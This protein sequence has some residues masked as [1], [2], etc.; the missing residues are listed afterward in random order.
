MFIETEKLIIRSI[1]PEDEQAY[2]DMASGGDLQDI[3]GDCSDCREWM[4][5][6]IQEARALDRQDNPTGDY[7]A[8]AV[9]E[10]LHGILLGSV[11]CTYYEDLNQVGV[12]C[13]TG[14]AFRGQGYAA[15][16]V[17]AYVQYF[18]THYDI[19]RL[20]ATVREDNT[21]SWKTVENAGFVLS[22]TRMY[23]DINDKK[24]E[25]Y[26]FYRRDDPLRP[27]PAHWNLWPGPEKYMDF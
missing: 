4:A 6:W 8:Y 21:A 20:I 18:F 27:I 13:F 10:K 3:F 11:G 2:I 17:T 14:A 5:S 15:E 19:H 22:E 7:L 26:R 1:E 16:A 25:L 12:T 9:T 23:R 24:E